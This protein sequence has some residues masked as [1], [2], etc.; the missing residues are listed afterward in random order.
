MIRATALCSSG[1]EHEVDGY[2]KCMSYPRVPAGRYNAHLPTP[3]A[4]P[5]SEDR[6]FSLL[7]FS[8]QFMCSQYVIRQNVLKMPTC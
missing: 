3:S 7:L 1:S 5:L 4:R 8:D 6:I 2:V